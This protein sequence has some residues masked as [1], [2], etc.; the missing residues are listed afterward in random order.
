MVCQLLSYRR[1]KCRP[2]SKRRALPCVPHSIN[3]LWVHK[4]SPV[5][6]C[7]PEDS[8]HECRNQFA[9]H[10]QVT[11]PPGALARAW[12]PPHPPLSGDILEGLL[13]S[14]PQPAVLAHCP[15]QMLLWRTGWGEQGSAPWGGTA[16]GARA[17]CERTRGLLLTEKPRR[18]CRK[19]RTSS[20]LPSCATRRSPHR[21]EHRPPD[22]THWAQVP[23]QA[24]TL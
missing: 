19:G 23:T 3:G 1:K 4:A 11:Q 17:R 10:V 7:L 16:L 21:S 13:S 8:D 9:S 24:P 14:E 18:P 2:Q 20:T 6:Q 22:R 5:A 15:H 12:Q